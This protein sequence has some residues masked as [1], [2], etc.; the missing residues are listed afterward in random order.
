MYTMYQG[1]KP[2]SSKCYWIKTQIESFHV[3]TSIYFVGDSSSNSDNFISQTKRKP[4]FYYHFRAWIQEII[5]S[6]TWLWESVENK[7][8]KTLQF[9]AL[10][11]KCL[12]Q[13]VK[14][15]IWYITA[16]SIHGE[17]VHLE[18]F[19]DKPSKSFSNFT[20]FITPV[21][22][23]VKYRDI[24]IYDS[25]SQTVK[26]SLLAFFCTFF[27]KTFAA[28][29]LRYRC[30]ISRKLQ[31]STVTLIHPTILYKL[32]QSLHIPQKFWEIHAKQYYQPGYFGST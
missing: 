18:L 28:T 1:W 12:W 9:D 31:L 13:F 27:E 6:L 10:L 30:F 29:V 19:W 4:C 16:L 22:K 20:R 26:S 25:Y 8:L 7:I 5:F 17:K 23:T 24:K 32:F 3:H 2:K 15:T 14:W 11:L 21:G